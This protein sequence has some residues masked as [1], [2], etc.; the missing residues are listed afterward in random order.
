MSELGGRT[1]YCAYRPPCRQ[2]RVVRVWWGAIGQDVENL[3][4]QI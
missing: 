3:G 2:V 4:H 1:Q